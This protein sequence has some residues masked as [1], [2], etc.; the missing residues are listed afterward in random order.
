MTLVTGKMGR[1]SVPDIHEERL[2]TLR[3]QAVDRL[4]RRHSHRCPNCPRCGEFCES[5]HWRRSRRR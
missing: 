4:R 1:M 2:K 5:G 3:K